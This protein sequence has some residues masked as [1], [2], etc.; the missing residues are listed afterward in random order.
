MK[1]LNVMHERGLVLHSGLRKTFGDGRSTRFW[2]GV[3]IGHLPLKDR[4]S[5]LF[6]LIV[7]NQ[8]KI[9]WCVINGIK[10]GFGLDRDL[11]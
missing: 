2:S 8:V 11:F 9:V 4:F 7:L 5:R 6:R 10:S 3:Q 1:S